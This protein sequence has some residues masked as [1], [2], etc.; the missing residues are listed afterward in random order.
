MNSLDYRDR[1]GDITSARR[2]MK[3]ITPRASD[4][5]RRDFLLD[6]DGRLSAGKRYEARSSTDVLQC[7]GGDTPHDT[8]QTHAMR[9]SA[10]R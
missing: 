7:G 8:S 4:H 3:K 5:I 10:R 2:K 1:N 9:G 6:V